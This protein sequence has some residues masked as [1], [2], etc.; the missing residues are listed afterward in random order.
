MDFKSNDGTKDK[1][2][3][4]I[5]VKFDPKKERT[6]AGVTVNSSG[7]NL[8]IKQKFGDPESIESAKPGTELGVD[9]PPV[10]DQA[11]AT[12]DIDVKKSKVAS[13]AIAG[14]ENDLKLINSINH[15]YTE[16]DKEDAE[17]RGETVEVG[18]RKPTVFAWK[19]EYKKDT[20][21]KKK[22]FFNATDSIATTF[23]PYPNENDELY[24]MNVVG[25]TT[26][27]KAFV[28]GQLIHTGAKIENID[29]NGAKRIVG[30]VYFP[31]GEIVEG[32]STFVVTEDN[33]DEIAKKFPNETINVGD[34]MVQMPQGALQNKNG[35]FNDL[36]F[37]GVQNLEAKFYARPRTE[38]EF[39]EIV[40][41]LNNGDEDIDYKF[42]ETGAGNQTIKFKGAD[43]VVPKQ[44]FD[45]YDHYNL[46]GNIK[47]NLD[48]TRHYDQS[49]GHTDDATG[50]VTDS[51]D[52]TYF[53]IAPD[54]EFDVNMY[55]PGEKE[56]KPHQK[57]DT[58]MKKADQREEVRGD[59][60]FEFVEKA[61]KQ[62]AKDLG[63]D[64]KDLE[65]DEKWK[66]ELKDG[67]ITKFKITAPKRAKAGDF[68]AVPVTYTYTNGSKDSHWF[69]FVVQENPKNVSDYNVQ[70][71]SAGDTLENTGKLHEDPDD[72]K[73]K[74]TSYEFDKKAVVEKTKDCKL[75]ETYND[76]KGNTWNVILD[77][78]TGKVTAKVPKGA[79][80]GEVLRV[81]VKIYYK[82]D[83]PKAPEQ[84]DY[85][86]A[87]F[88]A[89][90]TFTQAPDY[91]S[92]VGEPGAKLENNATFPQDA[93]GTNKKKPVSYSIATKEVTDDKRNKWK[94]SFDAET[95]KVT[96]EV[97]ETAKG[98]E[99]LVV[100]VTAT[101]PNGETVTVNAE[102]VA[103][104]KPVS[105]KP[106]KVVIPK[107]VEYEFDDTVEAGKQEVL[108]EGND[109][110]VTVTSTYNPKTG[111]YENKQ[112]VTKEAKLK[113]IKIGTKTSGK[114]EDT[115][116][117]PF[118]YTITKEPKLKKGEYVVDVAGT[119]GSN[120]E[121]LDR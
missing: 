65:D 96:A 117:I 63:K 121:D 57:S 84:V 42:V 92:L 40:N 5:G 35:Q 99:K 107:G 10:S 47:I 13:L 15:V 74:P 94:I 24:T 97:P 25:D 52:R 116:E 91:N 82:S 14:T 101:Y 23:N 95:G 30:Q 109:G 66:V 59:I 29:A 89:A 115:D 108:E 80:G 118:K 45:C 120:Q 12:M 49:F 113:K 72:K 22:Q 26:V 83:D 37:A 90:P 73:M 71:G 55:E 119:P 6:Y 68:I 8:N 67:D 93:E 27:N 4:G 1:K 32:T 34:V 28:K 112:E 102:F 60:N 105:P 3:Y 61:N 2:T 111:T 58:E 39:K 87:E 78:T 56:K 7:S 62:I 98:G 51:N 88:V 44:G 106:E 36:K 38:K 64:V 69:H 81:P 19:D 46:L 53:D 9:N 70:K 18:K 76:D 11:E 21:A 20:I 114:V 100:P 43:V 17:K 54:V 50:K 104:Q 31:T 75:K 41:K 33:K 85:A 86:Q 110:E 48:D 103:K 79:K 16:K 77:P